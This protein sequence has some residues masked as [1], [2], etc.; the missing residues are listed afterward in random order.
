MH[1]G[2]LFGFLRSCVLSQEVLCLVG[3]LIDF[4]WF[5][6]TCNAVFEVS[7]RSIVEI[8]I[9]VTNTTEAKCNTIRYVLYV[10]FWIA[11]VWVYICECIC[12]FGV[13]VSC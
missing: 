1:V 4:G 8:V 5:L 13:D 3:V 9:S 6:A 11:S 7:F 10:A 2:G 12:W